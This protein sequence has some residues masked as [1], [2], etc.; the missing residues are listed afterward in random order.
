MLPL[1]SRVA[2]AKDFGPPAQ[3]LRSRGSCGSSHSDAKTS[4]DHL[5]GCIEAFFVAVCVGTLV[6]KRS[7]EFLTYPLQDNSLSKID[8][9]HTYIRGC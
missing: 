4:D 3:F 8:A 9:L 7:H 6:S 2:T 5:P 1:L